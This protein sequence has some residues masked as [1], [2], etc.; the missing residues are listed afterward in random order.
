MGQQQIRKAPEPRVQKKSPRCGEEKQLLRRE[1]NQS[2]MLCLNARANVRHVEEV[3]KCQI[4][5]PSQVRGGPV[6]KG[7]RFFVFVF[8]FAL[9]CWCLCCFR[10]RRYHFM[11]VG[12]RENGKKLEIPSMKFNLSPL[13]FVSYSFGKIY[14]L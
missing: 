13:K 12:L 4:S 6:I 14:L 1:K 11:G 7:S 2:R 3:T 5:L 9:L 10:M 8:D